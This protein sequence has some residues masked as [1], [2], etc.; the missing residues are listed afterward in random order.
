MCNQVVIFKSNSYAFYTIIGW[1]IM[2]PMV[3]GAWMLLIDDNGVIY[4][5][6][7]ALDHV[8]HEPRSCDKEG[9]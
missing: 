1:F 8:L 4:R 3:I 7:C 9:F 5:D 2:V 6:S